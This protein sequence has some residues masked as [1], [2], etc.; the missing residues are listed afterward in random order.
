MSAGDEVRVIQGPFANFIGKIENLKAD[1]RAW[2]LLDVMGKQTR[3][4]ISRGDLRV[5]G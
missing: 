3:V 5:A 2:V 1:Q 4:S